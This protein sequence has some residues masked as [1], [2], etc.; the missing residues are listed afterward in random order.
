MSNQKLPFNKLSEYKLITEEQWADGAYL[1]S[2]NEFPSY[3]DVYDL[4]KETIKLM[5]SLVDFLQKYPQDDSL[6][7]ALSSVVSFFNNEQQKYKKSLNNIDSYCNEIIH[8]YSDSFNNKP[9]S[10]EIVR[11]F[12]EV[13]KMVN[14]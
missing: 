3:S 12:K 14:L 5:G 2:W 8:C 11:L 13:K 10:N 7:I 6:K 9:G 4:E 1:Y